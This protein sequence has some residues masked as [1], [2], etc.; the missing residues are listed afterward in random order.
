MA[1]D[2]SI[3]AYRSF[4]HHNTIDPSAF[5]ATR[6]AHCT[7]SRTLTCHV[8]YFVASRPSAWVLCRALVPS[9][10]MANVHSKRGPSRYKEGQEVT[11]R[12]LEVDAAKKRVS[13]SLKKLLCSDKLPTITSFQVSNVL[14]QSVL[15]WSG[16]SEK[17]VTGSNSC[18]KGA[19]TCDLVQKDILVTAASWMYT[20]GQQCATAILGALAV[21]PE[22]PKIRKE[23]K[24]LRW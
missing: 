2:Y 23:K 20:K 1:I 19:V 12:I 13:M 8:M 10:H 3:P 9:M 14:K 17:L 21:S 22:E 18:C 11:G 5:T 7:S 16:S 4:W 24:S 6:A 15:H